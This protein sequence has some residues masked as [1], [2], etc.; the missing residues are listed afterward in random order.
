[1]FHSA[2]LYHLLPPFPEHLSS[3]SLLLFEI[4]RLPNP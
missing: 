3:C 4:K 1:M 2:A